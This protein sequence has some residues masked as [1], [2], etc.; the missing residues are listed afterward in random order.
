[1]G[2]LGLEH[3]ESLGFIGAYRGKQVGDGK[4]SLTLRLRFRS[5]SGTLRHEDVDPQMERVIA[6]A[7]GD[8][9]ATLRT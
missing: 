4:K 1:M 5:G 2:G 8:L 9:G 6:S 3:F 7:K